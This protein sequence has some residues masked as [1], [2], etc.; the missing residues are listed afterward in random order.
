MSAT[1]LPEAFITPLLGGVTLG[2]AAM[3]L[4]LSLG[5]VAGIS[6]ILWGVMAEPDRHW[7]VFFLMGLLLG[8]VVVHAVLGMPVPAQSSTPLPLVVFSGL[9]VGFG[10][11]MGGGCTSGHGVCGIGRQSL[12]S[13]VATATFM[14]TGVLTVFI[15]R[16]IVEAAV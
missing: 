15:I 13:I 5:R 2:V 14:V 9:L 8:G 12:R 10:T 3:W 1:A 11:R 16:H 4:L 7:R 6:G